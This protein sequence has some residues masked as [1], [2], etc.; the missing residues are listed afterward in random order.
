MATL[1]EVRQLAESSGARRVDL[2]VTDLAGRWQHITVPVERLTS[3]LAD[4]GVGCDR[5]VLEGARTGGGELALV[6]DLDTAVLDPVLSTPTLSLLCRLVD[7]VT[8]ER[9]TRDARYIAEKATA[10][11][12]S[13]GIADAAMFGA[14]LQFFVFDDVRYQQASHTAFYFVDSAEGA[15]NTGRDEAPNLA[16]KV[17]PGRGYLEAPP[18][19]TLADFRRS[20]AQALAGLGAVVESERREA[21]SPGQGEVALRHR[22]L[23]Q[24]ADELQWTKYVVRN[25]ARAQRKVATFMPKPLHGEPGSGMRTH[26]SLWKAEAPTFFDSN[27]YAGLSQIAR[28]YIGG[29][30]RH[31]PA[32][33][34]LCCP[35]TNSFRRLTAEESAVH[36]IYSVRSSSA[37]VRI[38]APQPSPSSTRVEFRPPDGSANPYLA[39]AAI[40]MAGLDGVQ[41]RIEPGDPLDKDIQQLTASQIAQ[42]QTLPRTLDAALDALAADH[43]F[44]RKGDVFTQD[45]IDRWLDVKR[46]EVREMDARPTPYEYELYFSG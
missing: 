35:S 15:W 28:Y 8:S 37:V 46:A 4:R 17:P 19:D 39:F 30:L 32:L 3:E 24:K 41:S 11:L 14:R 6:P 36:L 5:D 25:L 10:H 7:P 38:P 33:L 42:V 12:E 29:L 18:F 9:H 45:V 20:V 26:Q 31:A 27:G 44:L 13:T 21:A 2:K 16:G 34:A 1:Y 23:V 43:A 22:P 40:L